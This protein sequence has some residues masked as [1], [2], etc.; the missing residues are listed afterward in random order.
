MCLGILFVAVVGRYRRKLSAHW[1]CT[2]WDM[3]VKHMGLLILKR[4]FVMFI[5]ST[6]YLIYYFHFLKTMSYSALSFSFI[7]QVQNKS[8]HHGINMD[9]YNSDDS[10]NKNFKQAVLRICHKGTFWDKSPD[11][12]WYTTV[13]NALRVNRRWM[14]VFFILRNY[15]ICFHSFQFLSDVDVSE[16]RFYSP[17][18]Y[19]SRAISLSL[20]WFFPFYGPRFTVYT[21]LEDFCTWPRSRTRLNAFNNIEQNSLLYH[22]IFQ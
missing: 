5:R 9:I 2:F 18:V 3:V 20:I 13:E 15:C 14:T 22:A 8:L 11:M 6:K 10:K 1:V 17:H 16:F 12:Q 19:F 21:L 4:D 7:K